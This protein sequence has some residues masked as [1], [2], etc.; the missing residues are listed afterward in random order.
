MSI[1]WVADYRVWHAGSAVLE[2]SR[3][4][5]AACATYYLNLVHRGCS[6]FV[7]KVFKDG[8]LVEVGDARGR[9]ENLIR[10]IAAEPAT[11]ARQPVFMPPVT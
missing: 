8:D 1:V 7:T 5:D 3:R 9:Q 11:R 2:A 10:A 4:I 6:D